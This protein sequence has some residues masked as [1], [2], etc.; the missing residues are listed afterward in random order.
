MIELLLG[1]K[2]VESNIK[3]NLEIPVVQVQEE[4]KEPTTYTIEQGDNLTKIAE[5]F[6]TS[7]QRLWQ[8]NTNLTNQDQLDVGVKIVIPAPDE[9]LADR[10]LYSIPQLEKAVTAAPRAPQSNSYELYSCTWW[11]KHWK[12]SVGNWGNANNWGYAAQAQGWTVSSTPVAG[13]VAW[14]TRG[15]YGHVALV[16]EV[17]GDSVV[18]QEGNYDFNGSVRTVS[19]PTSSYQYIYQ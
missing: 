19:V 8:K 17:N 6:N 4:K 7:W 16:L 1:L 15:Y 18:I 3:L 5:K 11:V 2:P 14:S 13:A 12:P 10:P 9:V